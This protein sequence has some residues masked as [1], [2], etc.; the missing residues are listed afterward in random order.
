MEEVLIGPYYIKV[1]FPLNIESSNKYVLDK[2]FQMTNKFKFIIINKICGSC[3]RSL[4]YLVQ[5][6]TKDRLTYQVN[7]GQGLS[8]VDDTYDIKSCWEQTRLK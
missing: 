2:I 6:S 4:Y 1:F 5:N 3:F 7:P 8:T